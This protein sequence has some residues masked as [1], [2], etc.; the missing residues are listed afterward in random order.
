MIFLESRMAVISRRAAHLRR[1]PPKPGFTRV[2]QPSK[3]NSAMTGLDGA[4]PQ[5]RDGVPG[6]DGIFQIARYLKPIR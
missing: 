5:V 2:Q 4:H 3:S 1:A 6:N